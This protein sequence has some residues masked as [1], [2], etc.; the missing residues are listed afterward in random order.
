MMVCLLLSLAMPFFR[1]S[2]RPKSTVAPVAQEETEPVEEVVR[3]VDMAEYKRRLFISVSRARS[4]V[5]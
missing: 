4:T 2:T 1:L 3:E 5:L